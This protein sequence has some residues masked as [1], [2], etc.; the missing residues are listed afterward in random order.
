MGASGAAVVGASSI[1]GRIAAK[2]GWL[3]A[4]TLVGTAAIL[5]AMGRLAVCSCGR[6]ALWSGDVRSDEN[7]QQLLDWYSLT[8]AVHGLL[9]YGAGW[10]VLRPWPVRA[11]LV[12]AVLIEAVWEVGE[13]SP[14]VIDRYRAV[15]MAFGYRGDSVFNS[16]GDI[17]CMMLGFTIARRVPAWGAAVLLVALELIALVVIRDNLTLNVLM[18]VHPI[19]A[20]R[21]WQAGG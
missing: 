20:V 18:L 14:A 15:T 7:S 11:R 2:S 16:L 12:V 21:Q 4:G 19:D 17:G 13:N 6:V 5:L 8:H 10:L 1:V 3:S 9:F